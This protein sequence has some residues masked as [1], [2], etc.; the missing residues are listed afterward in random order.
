[1]AVATHYTPPLR[2]AK[3]ADQ[4]CQLVRDPLP[5]ALEG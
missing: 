1:M 3:G 4:E 2:E 5:V